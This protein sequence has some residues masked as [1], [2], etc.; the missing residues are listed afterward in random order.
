[1]AV[2]SRLLDALLAAAA[3]ALLFFCV[4]YV[5]Y[6]VV[7][8]ARRRSKG[9]Y[10][11]GA[12][13]A[14][15][16]AFNPVDPDFRI[17]NEAKQHKKREQ[18]NPGDPPTEDEG[19]IAEP[20]MQETGELEQGGSEEEEV[21]MVHKPQVW[22]PV[23]ARAIAF[24]LSL[25]ALATAIVASLALFSDFFGREARW[26]FSPLEWAA[27][28]LMAALLFTSMLQLFRLRSASVW[29]F[30]GYIGL[31][32]LLSVGHAFMQE[33]SPYLDLRVTLLTIPV[34]LAVLM[35]MH[36]LRRQGALV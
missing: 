14:P 12:A 22:R 15:F 6:R 33:P 24:V 32:A 5:A 21:V 28:Y 19:S 2:E 1:M 25:M 36:R 18:D 23:L 20:A 34:A 10:A 13:L 30:A 31:G 4:F 26:S 17:V 35:Y 3:I 7:K 9:A 27:I 11:I 29:L 8:L 16:M